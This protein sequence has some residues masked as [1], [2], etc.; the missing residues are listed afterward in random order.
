MRRVVLIVGLAALVGCQS[1][2]VDDER[3]VEVDAR[4]AEIDQRAAALEQVAAE[5]QKT[6][7]FIRQR[8][9][10]SAQAE[11][12]RLAAAATG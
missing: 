11:P 4:L 9:K 1:T 10:E 8:V 3:L 2:E 12:G 6:Q 7:Q 5:L